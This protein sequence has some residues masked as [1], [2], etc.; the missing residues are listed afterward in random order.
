MTDRDG[1]WGGAGGSSPARWK[2]AHARCRL[3]ARARGAAGGG[4]AVHVTRAGRGALPRLHAVTDERIA[5]RPNLDDVARAL[6]AGGG[7]APRRHARGPRLAGVE[8]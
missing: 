4:P 7:P 8:P 5:K 6:V 2:A 3:G 1:G